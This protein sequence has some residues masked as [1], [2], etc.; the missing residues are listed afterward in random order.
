MFNVRHLQQAQTKLKEDSE[1]RVNIDLLKQSR[2]G[3]VMEE[4]VDSERL[5]P[6]DLFYLKEK[7][8]VPC[9]CL[10]LTG[11][12]LVNENYITGDAYPIRKGC[13]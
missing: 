4:H 13:I 12:A 7:G 9:D 2:T 5:V 10:I 11:A 1:I 3:V 6:G 8:R